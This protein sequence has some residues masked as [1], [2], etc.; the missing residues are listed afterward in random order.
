MVGRAEEAARARSRCR[1]RS[2]SRRLSASTSPSQQPGESGDAA[3]HRRAFQ[4]VAAGEEGVGQ[5]AVVGEQGRAWPPRSRR[6]CSSASSDSRSVECA[7]ATPNNSFSRHIR[8]ASSG[9]AR[10]QPQ[11]RPLRPIAFGQAGGDDEALAQMRRARAAPAARRRDRPRR[12]GRRRR[13]V[14]RWRR[15]RAARLRSARLL[16]GLCRLVS[17][18]SGVRSVTAASTAAG[19]IAKSGAVRANDRIVAPQWRAA[20]TIGS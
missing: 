6:A 5:R 3:G 18:M 20:A 7:W 12:S 17:R 10:I 1:N 8:S 13:R 4:I 16:V 9:A 11:R 2:R 15:S 19:S 14:R